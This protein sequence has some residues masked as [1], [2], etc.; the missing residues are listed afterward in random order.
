MGFG[1]QVSVLEEELVAIVDGHPETSQLIDTRC[2]NLLH[3]IRGYQFRKL[4]RGKL[5]ES[6]TSVYDTNQIPALQKGS[7]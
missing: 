4:N 6:E 2:T 7:S 1:F 5:Y 3:Q